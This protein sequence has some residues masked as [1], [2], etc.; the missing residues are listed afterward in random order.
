[1]AAHARIWSTVILMNMVTPLTSKHR[2]TVLNRTHRASDT[3]LNVG[4]LVAIETCSE[5]MVNALTINPQI[6]V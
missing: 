6:H 1:M 3:Q 5:G 4:R 2:T